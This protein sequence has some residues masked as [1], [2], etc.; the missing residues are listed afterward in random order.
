MKRF[1]SA[2]MALSLS[3]A[4]LPLATVTSAQSDNA[5]T[6]TQNTALT[7]IDVVKM[8]QSG[9]SLEIVIAKIKT[10]SAKFD[11]SAEAMTLLKSDGISDAVILAM[12][13]AGTPKVSSP[14][15][16]E[17]TEVKIPDGQEFEVELSRNASGQDMKVGDIV[18]FSVTQPVI[19]NG[20]MIIE[21]G[22]PARAHITTAKQSG[23]WG[24]AGKLE[25]AM[26]DV[27]TVGG[28]R[29]PVRFT[30]RSLGDSKGGTVA[31]AAVATTILLGPLG[32]LW[33]LKKGKPAIIPAGN[34][35]AV[36]VHGDT[37]ANGRT[38]L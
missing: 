27:M 2:L 17:L 9:L 38:S 35:Y 12:V 10:S 22:A 16:S 31:V 29:I 8:L 25:W 19:V 20:V 21:K 28:N 30:Q 5:A 4:V 34:R 36:F 33:G 1:L 37:V 15:S 18:D 24:K 26:K 13:E 6:Q 23:R 3:I 11:T 14:T 7:N 32:L